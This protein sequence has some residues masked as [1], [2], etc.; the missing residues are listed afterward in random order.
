MHGCE[1]L[2][3]KL[4]SCSPL[5]WF[6]CFG[7]WPL[8]PSYW[9]TC[10]GFWPLT[11]NST[12]SSSDKTHPGALLSQSAWSPVLDL[13]SGYFGFTCEENK[14]LRHFTDKSSYIEKM[15]K[16]M[17]YYRSTE[18]TATVIPPL[19]RL[20]QKFS[21][22]IWFSVPAFLYTSWK[23]F[24]VLWV[25]YRIQSIKHLKHLTHSST[26]AL[27]ENFH[28]KYLSNFSTELCNQMLLSQAAFGPIWE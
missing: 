6:T 17:G 16:Q 21:P 4:C 13:K 11:S 10:F 25:A 18:L 15:P 1:T 3:K 12:P 28:Q 9:F 8:T 20:F 27:N 22:W 24:N 26:R 5:Y 23:W 7:F 2:E 19:L 14:K